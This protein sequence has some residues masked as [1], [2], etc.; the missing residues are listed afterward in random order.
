MSDSHIHILAGG[1]IRRDESEPVPEVLE[2]ARDLLQLAESGHLRGLAYGAAMAEGSV[3]YGGTYE[4]GRQWA[5][6]YAVTKGAQ[7]VLDAGDEHA[8]EVE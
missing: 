7:A 5:T 3:M 2:M 6:H 8:T 4:P 1:Y